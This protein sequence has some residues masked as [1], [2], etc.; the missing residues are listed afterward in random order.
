V[1]GTKGNYDNITRKKRKERTGKEKKEP[2]YRDKR[3]IFK[4]LKYD[5]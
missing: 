5:K 2:N 1:V 4:P 3:L